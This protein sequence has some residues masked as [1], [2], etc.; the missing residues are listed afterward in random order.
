MKVPAPGW[1]RRNYNNTNGK[2]FLN[3]YKMGP[4]CLDNIDYSNYKR[5]HWLISMEW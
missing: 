5:K 2:S 1:T 3:H 4:C